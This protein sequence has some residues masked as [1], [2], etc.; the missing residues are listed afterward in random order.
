MQA[1]DPNPWMQSSHA[2]LGGLTSILAAAETLG[3]EDCSPAS[4]P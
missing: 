1:V 4:V 3:Y 2:R